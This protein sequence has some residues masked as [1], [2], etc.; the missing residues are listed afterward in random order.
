MEAVGVPMGQHYDGAFAA[1]GKPPSVGQV[2]FRVG[3][4]NWR[5]KAQKLSALAL[6]FLFEL[7]LGLGAGAENLDGRL[8]R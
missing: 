2:I 1:S 3:A 5:G 7:G 4:G 8:C 6:N